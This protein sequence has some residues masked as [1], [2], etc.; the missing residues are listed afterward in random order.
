[1][2]ERSDDQPR[3][4]PSLDISLCEQL[5]LIRWWR[6]DEYLNRFERLGLE[7]TCDLERLRSAYYT[8]CQRW[9]PDRF[10]GRKIGEF[11]PMLAGL[12]QWTR[13]TFKF[14]SDP[15]CCGLYLRELARLGDPRAEL[16]FA[17]LATVFK[18]QHAIDETP[19]L[20]PDEVDIDL[21]EL[22]LSSREVA[23]VAT[24]EI[25]VE[26]D[27][28]Q[29]PA[30][31]LVARP[32]TPE[33]DECMGLAP[34]RPAASLAPLSL[35]LRPRTPEDDADLALAPTKRRVNAAKHRR[36]SVSRPHPEPQRWD[37]LPVVVAVE[38]SVAAANTASSRRRSGP[39]LGPNV[40]FLP[41]KRVRQLHDP[42]PVRSSTQEPPLLFWPD[43]RVPRS[44][45]SPLLSRREMYQPYALAP[46]TQDPPTHGPQTDPLVMQPDRPSVD[47]EPE[48]QDPQG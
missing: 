7:P 20:D 47:Q 3:L 37:D 36:S 18:A 5:W 14:L 10:N 33:D 1:M 21:G 39:V 40:L 29:L 11:G 48:S 27:D 43:E 26:D 31:T 17:G 32:R 15:A 24:F 30:L 38:T 41:A 19:D 46:R 35:E 25:V 12:Y 6:Q 8:T 9:H 2:R 45:A 23:D 28:E 16:V 44:A 13:L 34:Q 22:A 42:D 4:D